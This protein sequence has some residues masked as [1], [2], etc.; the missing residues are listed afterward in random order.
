MTRRRIVSSLFGDEPLS[1]FSIQEHQIA[2]AVDPGEPIASVSE[3]FVAD[4]FARWKANPE[5]A[6][7][8]NERLAR[9]N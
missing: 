7:I 1:S 6:R 9:N 3:R 2:S 8:L 5:L 4:P